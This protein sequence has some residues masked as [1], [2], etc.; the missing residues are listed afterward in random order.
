MQCIQKLKVSILFEPFTLH[1]LSNKVQFYFQPSHYL[2]FANIL[3]VIDSLTDGHEPETHGACFGWLPDG[4]TG[5]HVLQVS[6]VKELCVI[7]PEF[8]AGLQKHVHIVLQ[9]V[10]CKSNSACTHT[11]AQTHTVHEHGDLQLKHLREYISL[12]FRL[13]IMEMRAWQ[14][15]K[16]V[17][18]LI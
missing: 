1:K 9:K 2:A 18:M 11:H 6:R 13:K 17:L 14:P 15:T 7:Q 16:L 8:P 4:H 10:K 3:Q 5:G 12:F